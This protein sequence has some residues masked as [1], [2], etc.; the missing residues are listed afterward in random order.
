MHVSLR[1]LTKELDD[2]AVFQHLEDT[3]LHTPRGR[4]SEIYRESEGVRTYIY[5]KG[6]GQLNAWA[7]A[8]TLS[9]RGGVR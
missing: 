1:P 2:V 9:H 8:R 5:T 6:K 4:E 7:A 3:H